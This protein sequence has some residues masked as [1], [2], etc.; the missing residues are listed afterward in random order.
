MPVDLVAKSILELSE[1]DSESLPGQDISPGRTDLV[2]HVQNTRTFH[3]THDL[4]PALRA[5]GL[6]FDTVSK[7][8]WINRLR[9]SNQDPAKNPTIKLVDFFSEKYDND[10]PGRKG[11]I[12]VTQRT[13]AA[14]KTVEAGFDIIGTGIVEKMVQQWKATW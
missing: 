2:Y 7:K 14:S 9:S 10:L 13:E 11:L 4:L 12:Y 3:W 6:A 5:S 1:L 8:E